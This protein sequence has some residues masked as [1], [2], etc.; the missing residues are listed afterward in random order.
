[1]YMAGERESKEKLDC[2]C[3][4]TASKPDKKLI[5]KGEFSR[6]TPE[7]LTVFLQ[8]TYAPRLLSVPGKVVAMSLGGLLLA[9]GIYGCTQITVDFQYDWFIPDNSYYQDTITIRERYW[10]SQ[11]VPVSVYSFEGDY[12]S[13]VRGHCPRSR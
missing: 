9:L 3:C 7:M 8:N 12:S 4:L 5:G 10:G 2:F 1:M 6:A 11:E 13:E